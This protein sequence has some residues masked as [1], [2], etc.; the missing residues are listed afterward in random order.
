MEGEN[1]LPETLSGSVVVRRSQE[2]S[3][4]GAAVAPLA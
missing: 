1:N 3:N 2:Q 4:S